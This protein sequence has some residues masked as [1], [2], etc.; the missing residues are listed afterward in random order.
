MKFIL[1]VVKNPQRCVITDL[2]LNSVFSTGALEGAHMRAHGKLVSLSEQNL[3]DCS[4]KYGN[5]VSRSY[6]NIV[7]L[8]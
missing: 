5:Y 2:H 1:L 4:S 6:L 8:L 3:V 7:L